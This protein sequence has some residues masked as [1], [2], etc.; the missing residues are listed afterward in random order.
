[1][2][3]TFR[4]VYL[5]LIE[6]LR[7]PIWLRGGCFNPS[8]KFLKW[9][10]NLHGFDFSLILHIKGLKLSTYLIDDFLRNLEIVIQRKSVNTPFRK[11]GISKPPS[12][13]KLLWLKAIRNG[14]KGSDHCP[15]EVEAHIRVQLLEFNLLVWN[16]SFL[17]CI[18]KINEGR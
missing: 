14:L 16:F 10:R 12:P 4:S 2:F 9:Y 11:I 8:K 17:S 1:M 7:I 18:A 13:T 15:T 6:D 5:N 3:K